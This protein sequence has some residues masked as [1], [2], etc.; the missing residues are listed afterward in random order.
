MAVFGKAEKKPPVEGK[1]LSDIVYQMLVENVPDK[2]ILVNLQQLGLD[3][4]KAKQVLSKAKKEFEEYIEN[5]LASAVE[6]LV[7]EKMDEWAEQKEKKSSLLFDLKVAENKKY[8]DDVK[9]QL[10]EEIEGL[11][12]DFSSM[13]LEV[14]SHL[15]LVDKTIDLLK[16][17]GSTQRMLSA[18]LMLGGIASI[19]GGLF[20][21]SKVVSAVLES[22]EMNTG[23]VISI[24]ILLILLAAGIV[25]LN[26]GFKVYSIGSSKMAEAGIDFLKKQKEDE[27]PTIQD[28]VKDD[29]LA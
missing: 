16:L 5:K 24:F 15:K 10:V 8:V 2:Q 3:E 21:S 29:D 4:Q 14:D 11:K 7:D 23:L 22:T 18:A 9:Q 13:K 20:L 17:S 19:A 25:A 26:I 1:N 6:K 28:L 12:S 27:E